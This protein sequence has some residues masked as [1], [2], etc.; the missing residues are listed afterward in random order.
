[1][2][3]IKRLEQQ[4][5]HL[6]M[7]EGDTS[8]MDARPSVSEETN[9]KME[10]FTKRIKEMVTKIDG[11]I[12]SWKEEED[13]R[14]ERI[15]TSM[16]SFQ[17][18]MEEKIENSL[19]NIN[20][21]VQEKVD[22]NAKQF[23]TLMEE[24]FIKTEDCLTNAVASYLHNGGETADTATGGCA[25]APRRRCRRDEDGAHPTKERS[26][27][28]DVNTGRAWTGIDNTLQEKP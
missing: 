22:Q 13:A 24:S 23:R 5:N 15:L 1:M 10:K 7:G 18:K 6:F 4:I 20:Q 27:K 26:R 11:K 9:G 2:D 17:K 16:E 28:Q 21:Q 12:T 25:D 14:N 19:K 8:R 3:H